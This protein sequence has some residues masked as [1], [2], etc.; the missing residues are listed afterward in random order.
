MM[1]MVGSGKWL[2]WRD[3]LA[4]YRLYRKLAVLD[5]ECPR[6]SNNER[7]GFAYKLDER[8]M[9]VRIKC[10]KCGY[11]TSRRIKHEDYIVYHTHIYTHRIWQN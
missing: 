3:I 1:A 5:I 4:Y 6:C 11:Y 2:V 8:N 10:L 7:D 9:R